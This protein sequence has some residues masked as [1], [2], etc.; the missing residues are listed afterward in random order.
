MEELIRE[1]QHLGLSQKEACVYLASLELGPAPVQDIAHKSKVNRATTYVMIESLSQRGLISTFIKGKKRFYTPETP[2]RL[3]TILKL[4]KKEIEEKES[5]VGKTLPMLMALYNVEG[6]KPQIRYIEGPEGVE[7]VRELFER[8]RGEFVQIVPLDDAQSV[9]E[10][11]EGR[12]KHLDTL[13]DQGVNFRALF[14]MEEPDTSKLPDMRGGEMRMIPR[15]K[16]PIHGEI[17]IRDNTVY[18]YSYKT[19]ILSV[20]ITSKEIADTMLALFDLAWEG[21]EKY[22]SEK[23]SATV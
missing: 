15:A 16:F 20:I 4:Q 17:T 5:E 1:L 23:R 10:L 13:A 6:A 18:L 11:V 2:E 8:Q 12:Q 14:V 3:L 22:P 7:T 9:K 19:S 21:A